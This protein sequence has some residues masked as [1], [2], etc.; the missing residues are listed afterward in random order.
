MVCPVIDNPASC[1]IH[2][3]ILF[4]HAAEIRNELCVI[5]AQKYNERR[6]NKTVV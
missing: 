3:I 1:K 6:N 2:T 4:F 5:Y